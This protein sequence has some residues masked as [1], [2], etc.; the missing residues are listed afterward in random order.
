MISREP[1][2]GSRWVLEARRYDGELH[3]RWEG[4]LAPSRTDLIAVRS[5]PGTPVRHE[6]RGVDYRLDHWCIAVFP[7]NADFNIMADFTESGQPL[8]VYVNVAERP[9]VAASSVSWRDCW[10]DVIFTPGAKPEIVDTD[11]IAQ[12]CA[13]G[14]LSTRSARD[15]VRIAHVIAASDEPLFRPSTMQTYLDLLHTERVARS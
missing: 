9:K 10:V 8:R 15:L 13:E 1:G 3:M 14:L 6:T 7:M 5:P 2:S 11:E 4:T 12:A